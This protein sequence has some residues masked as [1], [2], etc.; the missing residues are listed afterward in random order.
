[1]TTKKSPFNGNIVSPFLTL[2]NQNK[3]YENM[4]A[5][6]K[7]VFYI[8]GR[9][10]CEK[11]SDPETTLLTYLR[12][13]LRLKG[14]KLGCAEG[15]CGACTVM[16]SRY[17][18]QRKKI[19]NH[20]ANA[21]LM[22]ICAAHGL[23]ITTVEGIGSI[24]NGL[25]PVQERIAKSHGSQC[26]FCTPGIVMSMYSLIRNKPNP[27]MEDIENAFQG[28]LCR[29]TGY[30]P[31][32]EGFSTFVNK[33]GVSG[34]C[35]QQNS[36]GPVLNDKGCGVN[37][38]CC[39][40]GSN[41]SIQN[42]NGCGRI[43]GKC[44]QQNGMDTSDNKEIQKLFDE[45]EFLPYDA[46][47]EPIFPPELQLSDE[48]DVKSLKF[49]GERA[50]WYRPVTLSELLELK[51][52]YPDARIV[53]GNTE[54]GV[55]TKFKNICYRTIISPGSVPELN[56][57]ENV[58]DGI[59]IGA[60]VTLARLEE[61]LNEEIK[62]LPNSKTQIFSAIVD[63]LQ[64]FAGHQIRN[65]SAVGGN[66]ATASPIS[67]LNPLFMAAGVVLQLASKDGIR[68]VKMNNDFFKRYRV[69]DIQ[70][71]EVILSLKIPYSEKNEYMRGYKQSHRRE[72]DI[73][74]VNAGFRVR[75]EP[76]NHVV[77]DIALAFGGMRP[78]TAMTTKSM[79][80]AIG[81]KWDDQLVTD[82]SDWLVE[83]LPLSMDVPGG[84]ARYRQTLCSSFF[85]KF[86]LNVRQ[87]LQ[88]KVEPKDL[89]GSEGIHYEPTQG[90]QVFEKM[91]PGQLKTDLVGRPIVHMSGLK[92]ATGEAIY[93]DDIPKC[94][95]ELR[96]AFVM[97]TKAHARLIDV[98]PSEA[99]QMPGVVDYIDYKDVPGSNAY[100]MEHEDEVIF[101]KDEVTC[102]GQIIGAIVADT[103]AHAQRAAKSVKVTYEE[104]E[105]IIT[106]E[107]AIEADSFFSVQEI[108]YGDLETGYKEC[109]HVI[110]REMRI[111]G[112]EHFYLETQ[113]SLVI[114]KN[115][116]DEIE[117]YS[118][119]QNVNQIQLCVGKILNIPS[120]RFTVRVKRIGGGF[121]G[122]ES[123]STVV[124]L[125]IVVAAVK[126]NRP[127]RCMLDRDEDMVSSGTRHPYLARYK[128]GFDNSGKVKV[129]EIDLYSNSGHT[130][131]LS[132][133]VMERAITHCDNAY[134]IP[135]VRIT[136]KTCKT[137]IASN[138]AFRGFGAPQAMLVCETWMD[139]ISRF[140]GKT[141]QEVRSIN[142]YKKG[143]ETYYRQINDQ[144][145]V[146][147]CWE[148]C[149]EKSNYD[150]R[151][152][153][154][155]LF[156][157][158]NRWKKRGLA[159]IPTK[160]GM[161]FSFGPL[162]QA[163][164]LVNIYLDGSVLIS[165]NGIEIGQ[166][167]HTKMIQVASRVL[168]IPLELIHISETNTSCVPNGSPTAGSMTSDL[169]GMAVLRACQTLVDRIEQ[170]KKKNPT[171]TWKEW[172]FAAY[173]NQV[174][175]SATGYYALTCVNYNMKTNSGCL[176]N[177]FTNGAACSEVEIDC[178]TGDHKVL[179]TDIVMDIGK[180]INPAIDIG[181]IEGAFAQGYGLM[182]MEQ[183]K[184]SPKGN[185]FTKGP[186]AYKIPGFGD[187]PMKFNVF[188]LKDRPNIRAVYSSK[189][190]GEP[191]LF[192]ASSVFFAVKNAIYSARKDAGIDDIFQL[193]S[194]ATPERIRMACSDHFTEKFPDQDPSSYTPWFIEA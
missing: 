4:S 13:T 38:K 92:Q 150:E 16:V 107:Q 59:V 47:Q 34:K 119:T 131:D 33:C 174:S 132:N 2:I 114:P 27:T 44:C 12:E 77:S 108:I 74:I 91:D 123:R 172:V 166:G 159:I 128:V 133:H 85:F 106:I 120:N 168:Q 127:V 192:L 60:A 17:D 5:E 129:L 18:R 21:C 88:L 52:Q 105:P 181:Q 155:E 39:Q 31:I 65:V 134:K 25:H 81:R 179:R 69:T 54:V 19:L 48:F 46:S 149:M 67:D 182:M 162:N 142:L 122:K 113:A 186:G 22:P 64:W 184:M 140:L 15:G 103:A 63:M 68:D 62:K 183:R 135:H 153:D 152:K 28:N 24:K 50:T 190:L 7:L 125:P 139:E 99:L 180:S 86:F 160:Y 56:I 57:I 75:F 146:R 90:S 82:M 118:S 169:N 173:M 3:Y 61:I 20:S 116:D 89:S 109:D 87:H 102:E 194:P 193:N 41:G 43:N 97:S 163:G 1:M 45:S 72:D 161:A 26:G 185:L 30:R 23:A 130:S 8:N 32:L 55:E 96:L 35:C 158:K 14:T 100:G 138:T 29:C 111:G 187:I 143:E 36:N 115:E 95:G 11:N 154:I 93:L 112:Q 10:I 178:L 126:L 58:S 156:N 117:I 104:L 157:S 165:H 84:M 147:Q 175:L 136:G 51:Q 78:V 170:F 189:G 9:K 42:N 76:D 53:N 94:E 176:F 83:E 49:V 80:K 71:N 188:L 145:T 167:I 70:P 191:P 101:A 171:G 40:Q 66:I 73:A 79:K 37:G 144:D 164:A 121:G 141:A 137:N 177:Y 124:C 148:E 6:D 110:E 151:K 98:D